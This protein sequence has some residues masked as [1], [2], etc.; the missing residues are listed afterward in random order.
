L[1]QQKSESPCSPELCL[2]A[3]G[4]NGSLQSDPGF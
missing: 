3:N 2:E 1:P 4:Q